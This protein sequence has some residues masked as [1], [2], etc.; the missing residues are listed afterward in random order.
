MSQAKPSTTEI[1]HW[2]KLITCKIKCKE[3]T[4]DKC[5]YLY[6]KF[7]SLTI[8][9]HLSRKIIACHRHSISKTEHGSKRRGGGSG[10]KNEGNLVHFAIRPKHLQFFCTSPLKS[11]C[12]FQRFVSQTR[13]LERDRLITSSLNFPGKRDNDFIKREVKQDVRGKQHKANLNFSPSAQL[14][15]LYI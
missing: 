12:L 2:N 4:I 15:C 8:T 3:M 10:S 7:L 14:S 13:H 5:M 1:K 6:T 11:R 9:H